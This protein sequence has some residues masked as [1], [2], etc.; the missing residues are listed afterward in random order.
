MNVIYQHSWKWILIVLV[1]S[2]ISGSGCSSKAEFN[3]PVSQRKFCINDTMMQKIKIDTARITQIENELEL[4][5]KVTFNEENVIRIFPVI[6]GLV[7]RIEVTLG[8]HV[9]KGQ[10]LAI[11]RSSEMAGLEND[12]V[13][14]KSNL[15]I[16]QK[17]YYATSQMFSSGLISEKEN[18]TAQKELQKAKSEVDKVQNI[19][20]SYGGGD[21]TDYII[22]SPVNGLIVD[23]Q[24]NPNMMIRTD[25]N[26]PL[27]TISDLNEVW[28]IANVYESDIPK[29]KL[30][31]DVDI[32]TLSYGNKE[33]KGKIDKIYNVLDPDNKTMKLIVKLPNDDHLL[34]P[35]MFAEVKVLYKEDS[36]SLMIPSQSLIFDNSKHYVLVFRNKCDIQVRQVTIAH[37]LSDRT[38][39]KSGVSSGEKIISVNKLLIYNALTD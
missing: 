24:I 22:R 32:T 14:S 1:A 38:Y 12:L 23:K 15:E 8:D 33:F 37:S 20:S 13:A 27:F 35:E 9:I 26:N 21:K 10:V 6:S 5:G 31:Q 11:I 34:K 28:V 3:S 19:F 39:L 29:I 25:N 2:E 17:N 7:T 16:A 36:T 18:L 4:T 30:G